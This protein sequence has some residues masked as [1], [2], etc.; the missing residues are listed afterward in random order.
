MSKVAIPQQ[1]DWVVELAMVLGSFQCRGVLLLLHIVGQGP[2]VL[3]AGVL[4][5]GLYFLYF[6]LVPFLMSCVLEDC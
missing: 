5:G 6:H 1:R 3:A 4:A 2:A